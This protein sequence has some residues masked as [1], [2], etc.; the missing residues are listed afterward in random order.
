MTGVDTT[1]LRIDSNLGCAGV[2]V[3]SDNWF[4]GWKAT[5]DGAPVEILKADGALRAVRVPGGR[6]HVNMNYR[7]A[8][9]QW[10]AAISLTTL[11]G[12]T[13]TALFGKKRTLRSVRTPSSADSSES[14]P[15]PEH[16]PG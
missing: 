8:S 9:V 1:N 4:P 15:S 12:L 10:G 11:L 13:A 6:H 7:P 14:N 16:D 2:V 3:V 5:L